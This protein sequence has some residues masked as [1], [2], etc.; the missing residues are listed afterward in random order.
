MIGKLVEL[1]TGRSP[2]L[3]AGLAVVCLA[4]GAAGGAFVAKALSAAALA[5]A[6]QTL[7]RMERDQARALLAQADAASLVLL[8]AQQ[9]SDTLT[10][11][12]EAWRQTAA[13]KQEALDAALLR[14]TTGRRCLD[15]GAL[16]LLDGATGLRVDLPPA[17]G[18]AVAAHAAAATDTDLARWIARTGRQYEECRQRLDTLINWHMPPEAP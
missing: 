17:A 15:A 11:E 16:R 1:I 13:E 6:R 3:L 12:L 10:H 4:L 14:A 2:W 8:E 9:R 7:T 5:D 18:G